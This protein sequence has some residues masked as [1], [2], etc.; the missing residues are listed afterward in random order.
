MERDREQLENSLETLQP[1]WN[2]NYVAI[3]MS[4]SNEYVP[5]LSVC[6]QS[7]VEYS[8]P[9]NNY[10]IIIFE[11]GITQEN[12]EILSHQISCSNIS[13]RFINPMPIIS[14]YDL[15]FP[16]H[17]NLECYFR[18]TSPLILNNYSK[19]IFT[20]V[21]LIFEEDIAKLYNKEIHNA[22]GAC[23]DLVYC[24][25]LDTPELDIT[26]YAKEELELTNPYK[27]FNTGVML[28]NL[29]YFRNNNIPE[30]LLNMANERLYKILEQDI[31]NKF[32]K[33]NITYLEDAWNFPTMNP[34]YLEF[35]KNTQEE[36]QDR[37]NIAR[38]NPNIIHWAGRG[39]AWNNPNED[40]AYKWWQYARRTPYY[41]VIL[42]RLW[43]R[44]K[45]N[46]AILFDAFQYRTIVLKYWKYKFL[47][48]LTFGKWYKHY[49]DKKNIF[50][51]KIR[52]AKKFRGL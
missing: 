38:K 21:D 49:N 39:K 35:M 28:L 44:T 5:Y 36:Y 8:S 50:K 24:S 12:K 47:S 13:L 27:Y 11:R 7:L 15:K 2:D 37:Y 17:Y 16:S 41:E 29:E 25:F 45:F 33:E 32:F 6:L 40:L 14:Q 18:L 9:N 43:S 1:V 46:P 19:L 52:N 48:N 34:K 51:Q 26:K 4:S 31:L 30:K 42:Q 3:A 10:D 23:Q 22:L 20:D